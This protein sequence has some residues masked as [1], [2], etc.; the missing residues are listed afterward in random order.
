MHALH[1]NTTPP[2]QTSQRVSG[3]ARLLQEPHPVGK[4]RA[5]GWRIPLEVADTTLLRVYDTRLQRE[6]ML[7]LALEVCGGREMPTYVVGGDFLTRPH[8]EDAAALHP[9]ELRP[10]GPGGATPYRVVVPPRPHVAAW[11]QRCAAQM[12][13]EAPGTEMLLC[14][15]VPR[16]QCPS[17]AAAPD[18]KRLLPHAGPLLEDRALQVE[19]RVV[20]ERAPLWRVPA[21]G[22]EKVLPPAT[23]EPARLPMNRV[24]VV[25]VLR[26]ADG[27]WRPPSISSVRGALPEPT[28]DGMELLRLEYRLPPATRQA[29]AERAAWVALRKLAEAMQLVI[30]P[31]PKA[32]RQVVVQ[33]GG[34]MAILGVPRVQAAYWLR[35]SGC[36]GLYL[37]P[38]W[39]TQTDPSLSREHFSLLWLRGKADRGPEVWNALK[40]KEGFAG[41]VLAGKD[42]ALR[43]DRSAKVEQL[44]AQL[45]LSLG[46]AEG[47]LRQAV[48]GQ[49][50]WRL[51]PLTEAESWRALEIIRAMGLEPLRGELRHARMGLWRHA[52]YFAAVGPPR[53]M[54]LD[55]GSRECSEASL[56]EASPPPRPVA[57][58]AA[59][60]TKRVTGDALALP[61]SGQAP[62]SRLPHR[63]RPQLP[64]PLLRA[65]LP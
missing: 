3:E 18:L 46:A 42:I 13:V 15:V 25:L 55:D 23:W 21:K 8:V 1:G 33:H 39:T 60:S 40:H 48:T 38:F 26:R 63:L 5:A 49:R 62:S 9:T 16:E 53:V 6:W 41:L 10:W 27:P 65:H 4:L 45:N 59:A 35:G 61:L 44:Q 34:V 43:V 29:G 50:W 22:D 51:G 64:L 58:L 54:T 31:G 7:A 32:L 37:R 14:M 20:G 30:P 56:S 52:V 36:G 28:P 24:L 2:W 12:R 19:I 47:Q 17:G 11:A 57:K